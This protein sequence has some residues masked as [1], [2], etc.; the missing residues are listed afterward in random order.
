MGITS[1]PRNYLIGIGSA[2]CLSSV[3]ADNTIYSCYDT[4]GNPLYQDQACEDPRALHDMPQ[5]N[6]VASFQNPNGLSKQEKNVQKQLKKLRHK[7]QHQQKLQK[8]QE[9]KIAKQ[10]KKLLE[11]KQ[12]TQQACEVLKI[13]IKALEYRLQRGYTLHQEVRIKEQLVL[14]RKRYQIKCH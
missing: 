8:K 4:Q 11:S 3:M 2:L 12:K 14:F 6:V 7:L 13:K 10:R 1:M 9:K 5:E